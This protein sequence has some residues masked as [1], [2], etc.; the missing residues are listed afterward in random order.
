[1]TVSHNAIC[2]Q[3]WVPLDL[4]GV[5]SIS[6]LRQGLLRDRGGIAHKLDSPLKQSKPAK[7][8]GVPRHGGVILTTAKKVWC[9]VPKLVHCDLNVIVKVGSNDS[10]G[11]ETL[12][13]VPAAPLIGR[14][15]SIM[16][17]V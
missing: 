5:T 7:R 14:R 13:N 10:Q 8:T 2:T 4:Q 12:C 9:W 3:S 15:V 17:I 6:R 16:A 11:Q 1:M